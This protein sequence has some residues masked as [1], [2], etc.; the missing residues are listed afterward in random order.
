MCCIS[1]IYLL[2]NCWALDPDRHNLV[3]VVLQEANVFPF[4]ITIKISWKKNINLA[5]GK[6][7]RNTNS[8]KLNNSP[9]KSHNSIKVVL[10]NCI[11]H[12]H[13]F[14]NTCNAGC[15]Q[16]R[17]P[18][19]SIEKGDILFLMHKFKWYMVECHKS[20]F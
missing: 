9:L 4:S 1:V 13:V 20:R 8:Y 11:A 19:Q 7:E 18:V 5:L 17:A 14:F 3:R 6:S 16:E 15:M 2:W 10:F 12:A